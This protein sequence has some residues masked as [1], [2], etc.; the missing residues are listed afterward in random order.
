M[1]RA[2][3]S[4]A[5]VL[6]LGALLGLSLISLPVAV[7]DQTIQQE[8]DAKPWPQPLPNT[9]G[10]TTDAFFF[11]SVLGCLNVAHIYAPDGHDVNND[12]ANQAHNWQITGTAPPAGTPV[13]EQTP[14]TLI[15]KPAN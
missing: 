11:D 6:I 14:I 1:T 9:V 12:P 2:T 7:A 3:Q 15:V 10:R 13:T 8:C 5:P 4:T